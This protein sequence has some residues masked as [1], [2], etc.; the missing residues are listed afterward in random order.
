M[1]LFEKLVRTDAEIQRVVLRDVEHFRVFGDVGREA[2]C[3]REEVEDV[4]L[5]NGDLVDAEDEIDPILELGR[6][7]L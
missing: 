4:V 5:V 3:V 6:D 1:T 2:V 7:E